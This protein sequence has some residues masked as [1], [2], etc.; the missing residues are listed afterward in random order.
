MDSYIDCY[1]LVKTRNSEICNIFLENILPSRKE[2]ALDYPFPSLIDI[3]SKVYKNVND[4]I[5][6]LIIEPNEEYSLYWKNCDQ[7]SFYK[8]GMVFFTD[9]GKMI[10]GV[11]VKGE[12]PDD[13]EVEKK[14]LEVKSLLGSDLGCITVDEMIPLNSN[15]FIELCGKRHVPSGIK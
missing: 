7:N 13:I 8:H 3:P 4:L 6:H 14:Y 2:S 11:S 15:E 10:F 1:W 9:D 5:D 12:A